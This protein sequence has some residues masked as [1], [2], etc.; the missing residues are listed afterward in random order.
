M[1][2]SNTSFWTGLGILFV[3]QLLSAVMGLYVQLTYARYGPHWNENLFYS[4]FLSLPLFG[5]IFPVLLA[6]FKH[7]LASRPVTLDTT[8]PLRYL[9]ALPTSAKPSKFVDWQLQIPSQ[10]VNLVVNSLT[11]YACIWGVNLLGARTSALGVTIVLN[12]RKLASLFIS[13]WL[14][15]NILPTGVLI[16]ATIVFTGAGVYAWAGQASPRKPKTQ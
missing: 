1:R 13:I 4:H 16:G 7:L 6:Q 10:I 12:I 8:L 14:F 3:A 15:G 11:Q 9:G 5:P 2:F